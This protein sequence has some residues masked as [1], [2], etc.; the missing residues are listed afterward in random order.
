MSFTQS[1]ERIVHHPAGS[2][3]PGQTFE[4]WC[5]LKFFKKKGRGICLTDEGKV[6]YQHARQL[7]EYEAKIEKTIND[8]RQLKK[9]VLRIGSTEPTPAT[10]AALIR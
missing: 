2:D 5:E 8:Y 10:T 1:R 3:G 7:F 4:E 6:L 9:G